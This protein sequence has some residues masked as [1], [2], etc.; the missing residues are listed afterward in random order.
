MPLNTPIVQLIDRDAVTVEVGRPISE[1]FRALSG[2]RFH[3]LPVVD[4]G[5]L[6]GILSSVDL[7]RL[8]A[9]VNA[10]EDAT[11]LEILDRSYRV[12]D[13]MHTDIITVSHRATVADAARL[14]SAGG[15]HAVPV[16]DSH[17]RLL[18][19]VTTTDLIAH[20]LQAPPRDDVP[21]SLQHRLEALEHV[22][23][24]AQLYLQSGMA[25]TEHE[26]LERALAEARRAA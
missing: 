2:G 23:R 13:L 4:D 15:F 17:D 11:L 8:D 1:A 14:L 21:S 9:A 20:M 24:S 25:L 16:L 7:L 26:Q 3:H 12:E 18:G 10:G 5:R 22:Y 6:I 19:I